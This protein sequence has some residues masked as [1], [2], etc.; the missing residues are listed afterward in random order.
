MSLWSRIRAATGVL[1]NGM[2]SG[3]PGRMLTGVLQGTA[4]PSMGIKERLESFETMPWVRAVAGR[5]AE[6]VA[7]TQWRLYY[8]RARNGR[9][10]RDYQLQVA[11]YPARK[12]SVKLALKDD[13]LAE[14]ALDHPMYEALASPNGFLTGIDVVR[15]AQLGLDLAGDSFLLKERSEV[16][17]TIG[18]WP[19]P[20]HWVRNMPQ[21]GRPFYEVSWKGWQGRVPDTEIL[22]LHNPAPANPY[23]RG[24]SITGAL[25]D[26]L[27]VDEYL[28][29]FANSLFFNRM[30]PDFL[31]QVY[32]TMQGGEVVGS[33]PEEVER[34]E[35]K[36]AERNQGFMRA[37]KAM[38]INRKVDIHEFQKPTMEQLVY[39]GL[40]NVERDIILQTWG[41]PP[42]QLGIVESSNRATAEV[43]DYIFES[44]VIRPRREALRA[45]LQ[46]KLVPEYDDRIILDYVDT[47]P[48]D[49]EH[50]LAVMKA[51]PWAFGRDEWLEAAGEEE[52][53]V[54]A[55]AVPLNTYITS[56]LLDAAQ[57]P[58]AAAGGRPPAA[59]PGE[60]PEKSAAEPLAGDDAKGRQVVFNLPEQKA[61][62]VNVAPTPPVI[63]PPPVV[64]FT[65]PPP[66]PQPKT[67]RRQ[68]IRD[69]KTKLITEVIDHKED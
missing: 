2:P 16:G 57:R 63:I 44:R 27:Q 34:I 36:W 48:A 31:A 30:A 42:E 61:P 9:A 18:L 7:S 26:E 37:F 64:N 47:T 56:D 22:W 24:T 33:A 20:P 69:P 51:A 39:P 10:Q 23:G 38:F 12:M 53:G 68:I 19:I 60:E 32:E 8:R 43:S 58:Q 28:A 13:S 15:L 25:S 1:V 11:G 41:V 50:R 52:R 17:A 14:V 4:P 66:A 62:I 54:E 45:M 5:V 21:P 40:R 49:K 65:P 59:P 46:S 67:I 3:E 6:S 35:A 55:Y 29:K